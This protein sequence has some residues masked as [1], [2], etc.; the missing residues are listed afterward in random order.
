MLTKK[1]RETETNNRIIAPISTELVIV[2][3]NQHVRQKLNTKAIQ[4]DT[5]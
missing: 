3:N 5:E 4:K 1:Q 2:E